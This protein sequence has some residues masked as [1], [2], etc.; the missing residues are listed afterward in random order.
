MAQLPTLDP[1]LTFLDVAD[2]PAAL[3]QVV[4]SHLAERSGPAYW[5]DA[6]NAASPAALRD[7]APAAAT[8]NL[9][10]ARA[11]TGYQ[12][13]EL[14]RSLPNEVHPETELVVAPNVA[15]LYEDDDVPDEE[16]ATMFEAT[17]ALLAA[18]GAAVDAPVAVTAP[19]ARRTGQ[20]RQ[21][22]DR[23]VAAERTRA[24][25]ALAGDSFRSDVYWHDGWFQ[26]TIPYWVDLLGERAVV[27]AGDAV[28]IETPGV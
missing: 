4:G 2:A 22:A 19:G 6:R 25:L 26:T 27:A 20:V 15:A 14:V 10:V 9:R 1:G 21:A 23:V 24:G 17:L 13:Y 3:Y 18:T 16:A 28:P 11:F 7:H 5:V 12:H 8:R